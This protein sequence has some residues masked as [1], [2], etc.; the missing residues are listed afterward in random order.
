MHQAARLTIL[1]SGL[2]LAGGATA[3]R[4][5]SLPADHTFSPRNLL[6]EPPSAGFVPASGSSGQAQARDDQGGDQNGNQNGN[7]DGNQDGFQRVQR[8]GSVDLAEE[9]NL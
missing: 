5:A 1:L 9:Y 7:Q 6:A 4:Y 8:P 2:A 3:Y